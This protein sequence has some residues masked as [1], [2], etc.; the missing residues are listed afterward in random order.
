MIYSPRWLLGGGWATEGEGGCRAVGREAA[1]PALVNDEG[2]CCSS[3]PTKQSGW[4]LTGPGAACKGRQMTQP[5]PHHRAAKP[6]G[7][8]LSP[9]QDARPWYRR[10]FYRVQGHGPRL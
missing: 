6:P 2:P 10:S 7:H 3:P 9:N 4:S 5:G 8:S 1:A